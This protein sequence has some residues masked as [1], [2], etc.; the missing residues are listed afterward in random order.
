MKKLLMIALTFVMLFALS[1]TLVGCGGL[2]LAAP[3]NVKFDGTTNVITW[4]SVEKADQYIIQI[5]NEEPKTIKT[6]RWPYAANNSEFTVTIKGDSKTSKIAG[7]GETT[8]TFKPLG[9]ISTVNVD[10]NGTLSWDPVVGATGYKIS[11]DGVELNGDGIATT[12]YSEVPVGTHKVQVRPVVIGDDSYYSIW[13][14]AKTLTMLGQVEKENITYSNTL[15]KISWGV[16]SGAEYYLVKVNGDAKTDQTCKGNSFVYN[17]N[18]Q[19]FE[20]TVQAMGNGTTSFTGAESEPKTFKFLDPVTNILVEDGN[21]TWD[22]VA[23][24]TGYKLKIGGVEQKDILTTNE[25]TGLV[26]GQSYDIQVMAVSTDSAFFADW[27]ASK[28]IMILKAPVLQWDSTLDHSSGEIKNSIYWD[29]I[30]NAAGYTSRITLPSGQQIT[31]ENLPIT[32]AFFGHAYTDVGEYKVE[33]KANAESTS[34][35]VFSSKYSEPI[36]VKRLAAPTAADANFIVSNPDNVQQGFT[37]TYKSVSGASEYKLYK[38]ETEYGRASTTSFNVTNVVDETVMESRNFVYKV[39]SIGSQNGLTNGNLGYRYVNLS[40]IYS[41]SL[42]FD[43]SV[44]AQPAAPTDN[45]YMSGYT[46]RYGTVDGAYGYAI[47]IGGETKTSGTNE[48]DLSFLEAGSH[49]VKVCAKGNGT[50]VLASNYTGS[51]TVNRLEAPYDIR[52]ETSGA[53]EGVLSWHRVDHAT[54]Y[55]IVFDNDENPVPAETIGN[56]NQKISI[57]GT[58]VHMYS[59]ANKYDESNGTIYYMTSKPSQTVRFIKLNRPSFGATPVVSNTQLTWNAPDNIN[60]Q[61][62]AISYLVYDENND[63]YP[64]GSGTTLDISSLEGGRSYTFKVKA[65]GNGTSAINSEMSDPVTIYKLRTPEVRREN[66]KFVWNGV[67]NAESYVLYVDGVVAETYY[68]DK[69]DNVGKTY[70][71]VPEFKEIGTYTI[72]VVAVGNGATGTTTKTIDSD[73]YSVEQLV[74][75]LATP[76]FKASYSHDSYDTQGLITVTVLNAVPNA[77]GYG[78]LISGTELPATTELSGSHNPNA[79][80]KHKVGVYAHGG[81]F[82][83]DFVYYIDS[84]IAGNNDNSYVELLASPNANDIN[85]SR[86]GI[87][88]WTTILGAKGY[89]IQFNVNGEGWGDVVTVSTATYDLTA[90][91]DGL[92]A[93]SSITSLVVRIRAK[94]QKTSDT[95][96]SI[97]SAWAEKTLI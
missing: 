95:I 17:A 87:L 19:N 59:I 13:S 60:A 1:M 63:T 88:T 72:E 50:N 30:A 84:Q 33:I 97:S 4:N 16:V 41:E 20:V 92:P 46:Y 44:L 9:K 54:S 24:A 25:F 56:M 86:D 61:T 51:I 34:S 80:G 45:K 35:T 31:D 22:T 57:N 89:E 3:E 94:G 5:N 81:S 14:D 68:V 43:I 2:K 76:T 26:A 65:I 42:S 66:G 23:N 67:S 27:S 28:S 10:E 52:I 12:S 18:N 62:G 15:G 90:K 40:S 58:S 71:Y 39:Q 69:N 6:N 78:Y 83:S 53:S 38:N 11:I 74:K 79:V 37:V 93:Y 36:Y 21:L 55:D 82:D 96:L 64:S 49:Q 48:Y 91:Q 8:V 7:A 29:L 77:S 32:Q 47:A 73:K 75:Q 85:K 70:E